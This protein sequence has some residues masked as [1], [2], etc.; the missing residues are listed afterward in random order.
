MKH[1]SYKPQRIPVYLNWNSGHV[2]TL[3][4][5]NVLEA[6]KLRDKYKKLG[7]C[8]VEIGVQK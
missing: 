1:S 7:T 3:W 4:A 5:N 8:H 2:E 6:G